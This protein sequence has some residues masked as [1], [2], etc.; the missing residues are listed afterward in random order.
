MD[1]PT[2]LINERLNALCDNIGKMAQEV[3]KMR[4]C[5]G[6]LRA[7]V[8]WLRRMVFWTLGLI[9]MIV[10]GGGV[11]IVLGALDK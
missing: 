9:G 7:D 3:A 6:G 2:S 11:Q 4:E 10:T 8:T 1:T 5:M